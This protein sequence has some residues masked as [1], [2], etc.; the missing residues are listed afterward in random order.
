MSRSGSAAR[1]AWAVQMFEDRLGSLATPRLEAVQ[2]CAGRSRALATSSRASAVYSPWWRRRRG[3]APAHDTHVVA[4]QNQFRRTRMRQPMRGR[5]RNKLEHGRILVRGRTRRKRGRFARY[6]HRIRSIASRMVLGHCRC[7]GAGIGD[8]DGLGIDHS[9][10]DTEGRATRLDVRMAART[11][12]AVSPPLW[13]VYMPAIGKR[14]PAL[15]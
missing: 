8:R 12:A 13:K 1:G 6:P 3:V 9:G 4:L 5:P 2:P 11:V 7:A 14:R 15:R 10:R